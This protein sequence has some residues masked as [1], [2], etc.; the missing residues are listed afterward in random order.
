M[1]LLSEI[2]LVQ[3]TKRVRGSAQCRYFRRLG[4]NVIADGDGH[5]V[6][7]WEV[8]NNLMLGAAQQSAEPK[9]DLS[10]ISR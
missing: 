9:L 6:V 8:L 5:P 7:T 3:V 1:A 4:L 10:A 2:E